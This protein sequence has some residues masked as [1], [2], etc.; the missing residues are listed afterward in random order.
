MSNN[1][2]SSTTKQARAKPLTS[3]EIRRL[4]EQAKEGFPAWA[5][6]TYGKTHVL[7]WVSQDKLFN[8]D[9]QV[10]RRG[11]EILIDPKTGKKAMWKEMLL[12][13][14]PKDIAEDRRK[15]IQEANKAQREYVRDKIEDVRGRLQYEMERAG[16]KTHETKFNYSSN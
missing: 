14:M 3:A 1:E 6:E 12:G 15:E 11:Y 8:E 9:D 5:I 7:R 13:A 4:T 10:D 16:Y 2:T